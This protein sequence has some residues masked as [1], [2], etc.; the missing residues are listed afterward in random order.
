MNYELLL[1]NNK[2][3]RVGCSHIKFLS[4][5]CFNEV[6]KHNDKANEILN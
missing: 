3:T 2:S 4:E 6:Y 5:C 1:I